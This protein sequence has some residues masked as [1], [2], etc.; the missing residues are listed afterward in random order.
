MYADP[1]PYIVLQQEEAPNC[2]RFLR[3]DNAVK[4]EQEIPEQRR[5][6]KIPVEGMAHAKAQEQG[7]QDVACKIDGWKAGRNMRLAR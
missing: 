7:Q 4:D 5:V 2:A 3:E 1:E 6:R